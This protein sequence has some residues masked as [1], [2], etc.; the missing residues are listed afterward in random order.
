MKIAFDHTIFLIQP[1]GGISR[2]FLE[3]KKKIEST[4]DVKILCP[5][6]LNDYLLDEK[7]TFKF[8]KINKIPKYSTKLINKSNYII[9]D[10]YL[11]FWK[12]QIIHKTYFNNNKYNIKGVKKIINVWDLSHEIYHY[13][14]NKPSGWRPKENALRDADHII[15]SSKNTQKDLMNFYNIDLKKTSVIYQG[16]PDLFGKNDNLD[17]DFKFFLYVGS[18]KKYKNFKFVLKT[19][20]LNKNIFKEYKLI[21]FG[22]EKFE[23]DEIELMRKLNIDQENIKLFSGGDNVLVSLYIK[24]EALIY[25]SLNEG[26]GFPPLEAMKYNCSIIAS[27]NSAIKEAVGDAGFYFDPKDE[28]SLSNSIEKFINSTDEKERKKIIGLHRSKLFNWNN[29]S[30]EL[31]K[32]YRKVLE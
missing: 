8:L 7:N 24:A 11:K 3:L 20:A 23:K 28:E 2:Y 25:P 29:T 13:M 14:Y 30:E 4:N 27:E 5:I 32:V 26:F 31:V 9:N 17:I 19:F 18:R 16:T 10:I 6:Y 21:C 1:Y 15:C 22:Y 12:P